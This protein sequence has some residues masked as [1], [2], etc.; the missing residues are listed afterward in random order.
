MPQQV[1]IDWAP[2]RDGHWAY[3]VPWGWTW[4]DNA[5]WGFTPF[6]YGRWVLYGNRWAWLPGEAI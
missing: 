2:Y 1:A 3:V 4:V 6:H 5:P